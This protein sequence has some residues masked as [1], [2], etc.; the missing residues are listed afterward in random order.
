MINRRDLELM[1]AGMRAA[2]GDRAER[3]RRGCLHLP[4]GCTVP[5]LMFVLCGL[6]FDI[7]VIAKLLGLAK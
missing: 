3:P 6:P 4:A 2:S 7:L 1:A 5:L